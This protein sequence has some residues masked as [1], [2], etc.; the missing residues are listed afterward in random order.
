MSVLE[1]IAALH[2]ECSK[3]LSINRTKQK[4]AS[5]PCSSRKAYQQSYKIEQSRSSTTL[6]QNN[7]IRWELSSDNLTNIVDVLTYDGTQ[8]L[9]RVF[10]AHENLRTVWLL[11][12][13]LQDELY[14]VDGGADGAIEY[15]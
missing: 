3:L 9:I 13:K 14:E 2:G 12:S 5:I 11:R 7:G 4:P 10:S 15:V 1:L 8:F 6:F